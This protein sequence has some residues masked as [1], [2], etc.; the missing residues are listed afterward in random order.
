MGEEYWYDRTEVWKN[1]RLMVY[2]P[3][4]L[5][6]VRGAARRHHRRRALLRH[7]RRD[8]PDRAR[9][10]EGGEAW[11]PTTMQYFEDMA[12]ELGWHCRH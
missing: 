6:A 11:Q 1:A 9:Q 5:L 10:A 2:T 8:R 3:K 4:R 7:G 12:H